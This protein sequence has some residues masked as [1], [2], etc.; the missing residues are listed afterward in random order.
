MLDI[1]DTEFYYIYLSITLLMC[2]T[3][4]LVA[5]QNKNMAFLKLKTVTPAMKK[6]KPQNQVGTYTA[7]PRHCSFAC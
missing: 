1:V 3:E 4:T 6:I 5:K 2:Y 7:H